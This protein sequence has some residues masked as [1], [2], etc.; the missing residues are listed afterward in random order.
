MRS[1]RHTL[2]LSRGLLLGAVA[3]HALV[4][5]ATEFAAAVPLPKA[6][7]SVRGVPQA[8]TPKPGAPS[9][10]AKPVQPSK[11]HVARKPG[12]PMAVAATSSTS[13]AD[14]DALERVIE[15]LG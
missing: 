13:Q 2:R 11:Q 7:P 1:R 8:P 15:L 12:A 6:R 10:A 9:A 14:R 3:T 5:G 4:L